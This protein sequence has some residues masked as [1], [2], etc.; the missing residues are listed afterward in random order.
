M[1][2]TT[3]DHLILLNTDYEKL[4]YLLNGIN[5]E[6]AEMLIEEINRA[7]IVTAD[8]I[9]KDVVTMNSKLTYKDFDTGKESTITLVYPQE[10]SLEENK[11][12]ILAPIGSA[13][14]GL[15]VGQKISWPM[16]NGKEKTVMVISVYNQ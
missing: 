7:E 10:A 5:T 8:E 1:S 12:S 4:S 16:P 9:P 13:L 6:V 3:T 11:M 14:I 15:R 2:T